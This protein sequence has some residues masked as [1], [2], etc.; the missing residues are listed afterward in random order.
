MKLVCSAS[1]RGSFCMMK[2]TASAVPVLEAGTGLGLP[3]AASKNSAWGS[4]HGLGGWARC[5]WR[6]L[7]TVAQVVIKHDRCCAHH[8]DMAARGPLQR[9]PRQSCIGW[10][11]T[12]TACEA[13]G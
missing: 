8:L 12:W 7:R 10:M 4:L 5:R 11:S 13:A 1:G 6:S 3:A 2:G 9:Q